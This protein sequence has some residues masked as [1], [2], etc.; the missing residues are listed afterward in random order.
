MGQE[1]EF[2]N[3]DRAEFEPLSKYLSSRDVKIKRL[4][5]TES[6]AA[7]RA[8]QMDEDDDDDEEDEDFEDESG[9][10]DLVH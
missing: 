3:I 6:N 2:T 8:S 9:K 5:E 10:V 4:E 1:Y 7:Y